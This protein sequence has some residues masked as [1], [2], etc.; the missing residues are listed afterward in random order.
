VR[1]PSPSAAALGIT[2]PLRPAPAWMAARWLRW[3]V[4]VVLAQHVP[5]LRT[6]SEHGTAPPTA[7][8]AA[9]VLLELRSPHDRPRHGAGRSRTAV[10]L[11][12]THHKAGTVLMSRLAL[13]LGRTLGQPTCS[14][15][16][17]QGPCGSFGTSCWREPGVRVWFDCHLS[18]A[19]LERV[20]AKAGG[21]LRAVHMVRD[22]V[23]LVVSGYV[24]HLHSNDGARGER[25]R[26][27]SLPEG[28]ALEAQAALE[29]ALP[30]MLAAHTEGAKGGDTLQV[31]F[32]D[33]VNSSSSFDAAAERVFR[34][35]AGDSLDEKALRALVRAAAAEDLE[36]HPTSGHS[37]SF[38]DPD[39]KRR[40]AEAVGS[41]PGHIADRLS[42]YRRALGYS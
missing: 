13:L 18:D 32:E 38:T 15:A 31:R 40:A 30:E 3:G 4:L 23:G 33:F 22:P 27:A 35:A 10:W 17:L 8:A 1:G 36:R 26:R 37:A 6:Q 16:G 5:A 20:R 28:L 19:S 9:P 25:L 41:L 42:R 24:Y 34:Y 14:I 29:G 7:R 11:F 2:N 12:G 39:V 21:A